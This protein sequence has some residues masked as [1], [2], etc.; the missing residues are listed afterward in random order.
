MWAWV[1]V[2]ID[3]KLSKKILKAFLSSKSKRVFALIDKFRTVRQFFCNHQKPIKIQDELDQYQQVFLATKA[4]A[5]KMAR[6]S[7]GDDRSGGATWNGVEGR[8]F[9]CCT[10]CEKLEYESPDGRPDF[11]KKC[12]SFG[13]PPS[14]Q[15]PRPTLTCS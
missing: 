14:V 13:I 1:K 2:Y 11:H 4:K 6:L 10:S 5:E 9:I 12:P 7:L 8:S 15:A 3:L